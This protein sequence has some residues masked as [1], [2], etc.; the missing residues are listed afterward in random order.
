MN[1]EDLLGIEP[2]SGQ[3]K[4]LMLYLLSYRSSFVL[5]GL[6]GPVVCVAFSCKGAFCFSDPLTGPDNDIS[7]LTLGAAC[8][9]RHCLVTKL[10]HGF[11]V[12]VVVEFVNKKDHVQAWS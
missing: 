12:S 11:I 2:R 10:V 7:G 6:D 9:V 8:P 3:L 1:M 4:R 5:D